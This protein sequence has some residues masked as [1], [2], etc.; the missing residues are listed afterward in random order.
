VRRGLPSLALLLFASSAL[1]AHA[2]GQG[3]S[4][5]LR[6][7]VGDTLTVR[8][9]QEVEMVGTTRVASGDSVVRVTNG[10]HVVSRAI[11][12][13]SD[14]AGTTM[15][16]MTDSVVLQSSTAP[17]R[18]LE[19]A[20]QAL[21]G[22]K[23]RV[24]VAPDGATELL[25]DDG[26]REDLRELFAQMPATLPRAK[27]DVGDRWTREMPLPPPGGTVKAVFRLDSLSRRGEVAWVSMTGAITRDSVPEPRSGATVQMTGRVTGTLTVDRARGWLT[28]SRTTIVVNSTMTPPSGGKGSPRRF[29]MR[30]TQ[31]MRT[32]ER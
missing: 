1:P 13:R 23:V 7:K 26:G 19:E 20:R 4:L 18:A 22:Q 28:S 21:V 2:T 3:V 29:R 14:A 11:V 16:A 32:D 30:V 25:G 12:E 27:V 9:D 31:W 8:M 17:S 15:L 10:M 24:R 6:P 5:E